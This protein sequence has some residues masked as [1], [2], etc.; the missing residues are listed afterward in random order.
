MKKRTWILAALAALAIAAIAAPVAQARSFEGAIV[1]KNAKAK[2]FKIREDEGGGTFKVKVNRQTVYQ[3]IS[4]FKAITVGR[5][6]LEVIAQKSNGRWIASKVETRGGSG[7][8][9]KDG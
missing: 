7:G 8:G 4:G 2:T 3:G 9:G 1:A 5:T 6:D